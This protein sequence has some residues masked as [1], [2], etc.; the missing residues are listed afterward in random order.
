[1]S[2]DGTQDE[3]DEQ[4]K[5]MLNELQDIKNGMGVNIPTT[6]ELQGSASD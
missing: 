3:E 4:N 2:E 5:A 6:S 1:M